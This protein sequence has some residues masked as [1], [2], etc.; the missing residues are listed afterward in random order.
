[1]KWAGIKHILVSPE[2][3]EANGLAEHFMEVIKKVW[4]MSHIEKK[5]FEQEIFQR[6]QHSIFKMLDDFEIQWEKCLIYDEMVKNLPIFCLILLTLS[7][8]ENSRDLNQ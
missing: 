7:K 1:M 6:C 5:N 4:H 8:N 3:P 2:D